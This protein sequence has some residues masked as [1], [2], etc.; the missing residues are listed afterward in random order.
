MNKYYDRGNLYNFW[1][2]NIKKVINIRKSNLV[3]AH[4]IIEL[5][6]LYLRSEGVLFSEEEV[7]VQ[8]AVRELAGVK[9]WKSWCK[10]LRGRLFQAKNAA[11]LMLC[12]ALSR[13]LLLPL[14]GS[15]VNSDSPLPFLPSLLRLPF[16]ICLS[17]VFRAV[18]SLFSSLFYSD[19]S[20]S[21]P[22]SSPGSSFIPSSSVSSFSFLL[23]STW[24]KSRLSPTAIFSAPS[25]GLERRIL[26]SAGLLLNH[27]SLSPSRVWGWI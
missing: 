2:G 11:H 9:R 3:E 5:S 13:S 10:D 6:S 15:E 25:V 21:S 20:S 17:L 4:K 8:V 14:S 24:G 22:F 23:G 12:T 19:S 16:P 7:A 27:F 26:S 18:F 1:G